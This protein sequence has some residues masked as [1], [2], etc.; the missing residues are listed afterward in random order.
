MAD[1]SISYKD[2]ILKELS[3]SGI[4]KL[5]T[6][7]KY[8]EDDVTVNYTAPTP[9]SSVPVIDKILTNTLNR[10]TDLSSGSSYGIAHRFDVNPDLIVCFATDVTSKSMTD[11]YG[12]G[13]ECILALTGHKCITGYYDSTGTLI[14]EYSDSGLISYWQSV[15]F[16]VKPHASGYYMRKG[17][18]RWVAIK[19]K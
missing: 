6:K 16:T 1:V 19:F 11:I 13:G 4:I 10:T 14:E 3:E 9:V 12:I 17:I 5:L 18:Y 8:L 2:G 7:G 15:T